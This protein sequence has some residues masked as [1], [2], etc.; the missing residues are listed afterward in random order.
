VAVIAASAA[1][2]HI[3]SGRILALR[4]FDIAYG[5]DLRRAEALWAAGAHGAGQRRRL[6]A[7]PAKAVSF[8]VPPLVLPLGSVSLALD[9]ASVQATATAR[10]YDFGAV[11][12]AL[13]VA[14]DDL[15]W[16]AFT[17]RAD[18]VDRA[19]GP[20]AAAQPWPALLDAVRGAVAAA[21]D[22]PAAALVEEDY[23]IAQVT[24]FADPMTAEALLG[25]VDLAPLLVGAQ[26]HPLSDGARADLLR[27]RFSWHVDDLVVLGWDRAFVLE[28]RAETDV[29]DV[30]EV[31]NAQLLEMR[32]YDELLDAELPRMYELVAAARRGVRLVAS[33]RY[34][35]LARQLNTLVA[36][37]TEQT[38]RVDNALQVT[39][40]VHLARVYAAAM[41]LFRVPA[42]SAAVDRKL[43]VIRD[44][45]RGLHEE[46][47]G[48][49]A[50]LLEVAIVALI[51]LEIVLSM[52]RH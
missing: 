27:P 3:R 8:G 47:S 34:A 46:A 44:T 10:L 39:E 16:A 30:L 4:L 32:F 43:A 28:P 6:S 29:V 19:S 51:M 26:P 17:A 35:R 31:A 23:L 20:D 49:R 5:I 37:V 18:A 33:R 11:A 50:E 13:E 1:G 38:E 42:V 40:D 24:A 21:L 9:G 12:L 36:E 25:A 52:V 45:Y 14:A 7:T 2:P 15:D 48:A 22:R 41:T